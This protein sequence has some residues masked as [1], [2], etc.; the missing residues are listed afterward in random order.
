[1]VHGEDFSGSLRIE[2]FS[3]MALNLS[4]VWKFK[5]RLEQRF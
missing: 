5:Q 1:M 2:F 4:L 3:Q